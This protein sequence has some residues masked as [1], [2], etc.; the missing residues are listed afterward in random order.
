MTLT[1]VSHAGHNQVPFSGRIRGKV[2]KPG[3]YT[4]R[5]IA[6]A[7]TSTATKTKSF[8]FRVVSP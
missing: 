1:R 3:T 8:S 6:T 7:A 2:L 5:F 4:A